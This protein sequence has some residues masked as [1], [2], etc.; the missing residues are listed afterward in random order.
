VAL[1]FGLGMLAVVSSIALDPTSVFILRHPIYILFAFLSWVLLPCAALTRCAADHE[2]FEA[3][4]VLMGP[5]V[6]LLGA[7]PSLYSGV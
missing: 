4:T 6:H 3:A 7:R 5:V 1:L 2:D